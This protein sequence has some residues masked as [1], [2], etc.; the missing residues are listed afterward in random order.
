M[1]CTPQKVADIVPVDMVINLMIVAAWRVSTSK[2]KELLIYN[3]CTGQQNPIKW[4]DFIDLCFK[5]M[6]KHPFSEINWYPDGTVT[7]SRTMNEI[8]RYLFHWLP[9]YVMDGI[10][11]LTGGKPM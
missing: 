4:G 10:I 8:N 9:A 11:W 3:C 2:P 1:L 5:F 7:A 6:R